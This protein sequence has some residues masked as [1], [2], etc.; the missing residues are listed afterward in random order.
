MSKEIKKELK[1]DIGAMLDAL[2]GDL[3]E[4]ET[5]PPSTNQPVDE[6][7]SKTEAP[8]TDEPELDEDG[9]ETDQ[10][11][12]DAPTTD[13]PADDD[14]WAKVMEENR[15]L[16]EDLAKKKVEDETPKT[17]PPST[18]AP[19]EVQDFIKDIDLDDLSRDPDALNDVLNTVFAK[20][21]EQV[22]TEQ[23]NIV[24][25]TLARVPEMVKTSIEVQE[26]LAAI[27]NK[28][29]AEN[30][31]LQGFKKVV[32]VVFDELAQEN[33][34]GTYEEILKDVSTQVRDRLG[35]KKSTRRTSDNDDPPKLP[36]KRGKARVQRTK[37]KTGSI[38]NEIA[39]MDAALNN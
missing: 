24:S 16:K 13:E 35:L 17:S 25:R 37:P 19:I 20:A 15:K 10:P 21:V 6:D 5:D 31:D 29:Y 28:F 9:L 30:E 33:P 39:D 36:H 3:G 12:T 2:T 23:S 32:G 1:Y 14:A 8:T 26:N 38:A 7:E 4:V 11:K 18:S 22:R 34:D 27:S